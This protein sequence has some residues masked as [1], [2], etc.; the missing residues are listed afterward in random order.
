MRIGLAFRLFFKA[1]FDGSTAEKL[2]DVLNGKLPAL[3][4]APE[5]KLEPKPVPKLAPK[6]VPK[7]PARSD[8]LTLLAALQREARFIDIIQ[9]PLDQYND[10]Q[11]GGAAR[12]VLKDCG[13]VVKRIFDL[14]TVVA[15]EEGA[16]V[17][18]PSD[19]DAG[20]YR[21]TGNVGNETPTAGSLVHHG[22]RANQCDV[23]QWSGSDEAAMIVAPAEIEIK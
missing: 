18:L 13:K 11:V 1:L 17:D 8:A 22:W 20:M 3:P 9:E 15:E 12:E 21:L 5:P 7:P 19:F 6:P 2:S 10:A 16:N 14:Q 23:G 4:E